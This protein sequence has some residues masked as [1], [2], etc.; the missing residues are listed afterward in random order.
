MLWEIERGNA[1]PLGTRSNNTLFLFIMLARTS[2]YLRAVL[3]SKYRTK[4]E[5][6]QVWSTAQ[7]NPEVIPRQA[8]HGNRKKNGKN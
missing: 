1:H 7:G 6:L 2:Q 8:L 5:R 3:D 4:E